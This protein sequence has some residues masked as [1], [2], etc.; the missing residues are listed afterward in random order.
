MTPHGLEIAETEPAPSGPVIHS[1]QTYDYMKHSDTQKYGHYLKQLTTQE[2]EKL[3]ACVLHE[4]RRRDSD[5]L[6]GDVMHTSKLLGR[7]RVAD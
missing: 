1:H 7:I 2:I 3:L 6:K 5:R 4:M